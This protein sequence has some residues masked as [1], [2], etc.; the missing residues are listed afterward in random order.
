MIFIALTTTVSRRFWEI[1]YITLLLFSISVMSDSLWPHELQQARLQSLLRLISIELVMSSDLLIFSCPL[2]LLPSVFPSV[3]VFSS[4]LALHIRWS[5]YWSFSFRISPSS[6]Y[7]GLTSFKIN[8]FDLLEIQGTHM[9]I[10]F[11]IKIALLM[12][13]ELFI[14]MVN[15]NE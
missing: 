10:F 14:E 2:L 6:E 7:L 13:F 1:F 4:E 15:S 9:L 5:K 12:H 8:W 3:R 11:F